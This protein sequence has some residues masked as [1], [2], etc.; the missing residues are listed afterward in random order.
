V[1]QIL[2]QLADDPRLSLGKGK[3]KFSTAR[4]LVAFALPILARFARNMLFP[5]YGRARFDA[6]IENYLHAGSIAPGQIDLNGYEPLAFM[7]GRS[8]GLQVLVAA[9]HSDLWSE[10]GRAGT[11]H[12]TFR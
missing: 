1:S 9:V 8:R 3:F 11:A 12:Q 7:Q 6:A 4:R 2:D 10:H 5:K